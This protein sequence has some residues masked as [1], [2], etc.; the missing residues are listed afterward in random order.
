[1]P[2]LGDKAKAARAS[3]ATHLGNRLLPFSQD[4]EKTRGDQDVKMRI[5][6]RYGERITAFELA[7][8]QTEPPSPRA[9]ASQLAF[10]PIDTQNT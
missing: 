3:D 9:S 1:M 4:G 8:L 10:G 7:I 5:V 2:R 6:H